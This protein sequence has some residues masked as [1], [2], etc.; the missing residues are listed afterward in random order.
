M[1]ILLLLM[2]MGS[3][4][5]LIGCV[6]IGLEMWAQA[7]VDTSSRQIRAMLI[8]NRFGMDSGKEEQVINR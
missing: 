2:V 5:M 7:R 3:G 6:V 4:V 8:P 1:Y